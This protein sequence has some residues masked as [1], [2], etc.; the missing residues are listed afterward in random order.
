MQRRRSHEEES[1]GEGATTEAIQQRE[2]ND[3]DNKILL[4][5]ARIAIGVAVRW[6]RVK[7]NEQQSEEAEHSEHCKEQEVPKYTSRQLLC[8]R[9]LA[10]QE[11]R[12]IQLRT[13]DGF[14]AIHCKDCG[15]QERVAFNLCTC[16][17]LWHGCDLHRIDPKVHASRKGAKVNTKKKVEQGRARGRLKT[18]S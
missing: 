17:V 9:C 2:V 6:K 14:R 16:G 7:S 11:T 3:C 12:R 18:R 15:K 13:T 10:P 8:T 5:Y 4:K 1:K